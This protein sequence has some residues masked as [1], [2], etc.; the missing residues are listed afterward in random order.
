MKYYLYIVLFI[1]SFSACTFETPKDKISS[2]DKLDCN[3]SKLN[4]T[5]K[6]NK[7]KFN[8]DLNQ[9]NESNEMDTSKLFKMV[10]IPS[11]SFLM[12]SEHD[13]MAL[14]R[15][16]P[17]HKVEVSSFYMDVHEVTNSQFK[18]F[19]DAT[20]YVTIAERPIDWEEMKKQLP[21]GTR[22]P[23]ED[24]LQPGS[25]VFSSPKNIVN[26][27]DFSN[28]WKWVKG[29][30]WKHPLGPESDIANKANHPVVQ[31]AYQ[32]AIAYAN[33]AGKR[34]PTEAE[35]EWAAKGGLLSNYYPWGNEQVGSGEVKC[36]YWSGK[37]PTEN[38][39]K[40]GFYY[41]APVI[42]Y[43]P[44]G[45]GLYNM[46]GNVWEICSD[47]FDENYYQDC[48]KLG[49]IKN[50]QGPAKSNYSMEPY[51]KKR[52][53]RGGSFLCNDSYCA[54]Y[55]VTARMPFS[56]DSGTNHT[57]FRCVSDIEK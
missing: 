7:S 32:D 1:I 12:G 6:E 21:P 35:W 36:N 44:N 3:H 46:A 49:L 4:N 11:G 19:V 45:Y 53:T 8:L 22:K 25:L 2:K 56:E 29:A 42:S 9:W 37:F 10:R 24:D 31:I 38:S 33:W 41:T 26:L 40:D 28:W 39:K 13:S 48:F 14:P 57:G 43:Q 51:E 16:K 52:V 50:P 17:V 27:A 55:R 30:C 54:S 15:E 47:W 20:N 23:P 18:K 5:T 34:L